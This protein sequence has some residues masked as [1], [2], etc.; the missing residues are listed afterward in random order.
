MALAAQVFTRPNITV[1]VDCVLK[2]IIYLST[3]VQDHNLL[4]T[5]KSLFKFVSVKTTQNW[6]WNALV[7]IKK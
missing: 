3:S 4:T 7:R 6:N 1:M 2:S 5:C